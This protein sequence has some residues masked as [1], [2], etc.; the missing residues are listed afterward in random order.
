[1]QMYC[2]IIQFCLCIKWLFQSNRRFPFS[3]LLRGNKFS[4]GCAP[5]SKFSSLVESEMQY[6]HSKRISSRTLKTWHFTKFGYTSILRAG[7]LRFTVKASILREWDHICLLSML[8]YGTKTRI[9][10][11]GSNSKYINVNQ[12]SVTYYFLKNFSLNY[13]FIIVL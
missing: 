6:Q 10:I 12:N 8:I 1:M 13:S 4:L 2:I 9:K 5:G 11:K 7:I 3:L